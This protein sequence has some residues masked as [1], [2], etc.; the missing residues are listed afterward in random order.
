MTRAQLEAIA[1]RVE[2]AQRAD[3][4]LD[5]LVARAAGWEAKWHDSDRPHGWYWRRGDNSW[6]AECDGYPP[7]YTSSLDAAA[8][9]EKPHHRVHV[10]QHEKYVAAKVWDTRTKMFTGSASCSGD[11]AEPRA[12][13]AAAL[14][15]RAMEAA[16]E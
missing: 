12:R 16:D 5:R 1:A 2:A 4:E 15:A 14:R 7:A 13:T 8:S 11:H 6:T 9:L 10:V 3:R